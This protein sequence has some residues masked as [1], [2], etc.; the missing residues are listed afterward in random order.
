MQ[1][2]AR[3]RSTLPLLAMGA[4]A[5]RRLHQ[6]SGVQR[7]LGHRVTELIAVP[8][9][10]LLMKMLH[11][12]VPILVAEKPEHPLKFLP[13]RPARRS[14]PQPTVGKPRIAFILVAPGP[15]LEGAHMHPQHLRRLL[16]RDLAPILPI[17]Q[18]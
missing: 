14:S 15:A 3:Q 11:R 18:T 1:H 6:P 5:A 7:E 12:E 8:L 9:H 2:H 10:Q 16:L 17:Q 4:A 13:R